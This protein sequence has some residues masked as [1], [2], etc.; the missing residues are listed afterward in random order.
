MEEKQ[1]DF[2][3]EK[4]S[5]A[6]ALTRPMLS[7]LSLTASWAGIS[8]LMKATLA[9]KQQ[10]LQ[11]DYAASV[12]MED[13]DFSPACPSSL[14]CRPLESFRLKPWISSAHADP[15]LVSRR[16][17]LHSQRWGNM[18]HQRQAR[19]A[20]QWSLI[21]AQ[22][23]GTLAQ[24]DM[25]SLT[26]NPCCQHTWP[27]ILFIILWRTAWLMMGRQGHVKGK[28]M[29][30][31][32]AWEYLVLPYRPEHWV[33]AQWT[34]TRFYSNTGSPNTK[35]KDLSVYSNQP[36]RIA[37]RSLLIRYYLPIFVQSVWLAW[38]PF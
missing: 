19:P 38:C 4:L 23:L 17:R 36:I 3:S 16:L 27:I 10:Q 12:K 25:V 33:H 34:L 15:V 29:S 5:K 30:Y 18:P 13:S 22:L 14:P 2:H 1:Y 37:C 11:T 6:E 8:C 20:L 26:R 31:T 21:R 28:W 24:D 9:S 32:K 35:G 7:M